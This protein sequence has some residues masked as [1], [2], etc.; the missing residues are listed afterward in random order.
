MATKK[1]MPRTSSPKLFIDQKHKFSEG[2]KPSPL[3]L[4]LSDPA[5]GGKSQDLHAGEL[6]PQN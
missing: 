1:V 4:S 2:L 5:K 6:R 3:T